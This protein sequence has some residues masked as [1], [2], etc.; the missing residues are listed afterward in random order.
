LAPWTFGFQSMMR[1]SRREQK[2]APRGNETLRQVERVLLRLK[3][4]GTY[5]PFSSSYLVFPILIEPS[6]EDH[7]PFCRVKLESP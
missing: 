7:T 6:A 5:H 2:R 3:Q 4:G 1:T